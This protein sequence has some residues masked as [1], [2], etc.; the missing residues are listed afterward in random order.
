MKLGLHSYFY[1]R[2]ADH[3]AFST[4]RKTGNER[5]VDTFSP[6]LEATERDLLR[7]YPLHARRH[8][9]PR[10]DPEIPGGVQRPWLNLLFSSSWIDSVTK[11]AERLAT[12]DPRYKNL[13][14]HLYTRYSLE[15]IPQEF[16]TTQ[17]NFPSDSQALSIP[18]RLHSSTIAGRKV[19]SCFPGCTARV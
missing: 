9:L 7:A 2:P 12:P 10:L 3:M 4:N 13:N 14:S 15:G 16:G 6:G 1:P 18:R 8:S 11:V 17:P 19:A 5:L